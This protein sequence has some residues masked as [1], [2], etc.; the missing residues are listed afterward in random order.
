MQKPAAA[1]LHSRIVSIIRRI[2]GGKVS[3]YGQ[4]A[5]LAGNPRAAR[6]VVRAL[7]SSSDKQK[8]PWH[9]VINSR[10]MISLQRGQGFELQQALLRDEGVA[11]SDGG[12]VDLKRFLWSGPRLRK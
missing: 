4:I 11:V 1:S 7:H 5:A 10:G 2:P 12:Q 3:T 6:Q 9:R 8:L